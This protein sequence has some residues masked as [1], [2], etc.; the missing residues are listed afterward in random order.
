MATLS[1]EQLQKMRVDVAHRHKGV[2]WQKSHVNAAFQALE[3]WFEN[4][5]PKFVAL[6]DIALAPVSTTNVQKKR[7]V[8]AYLQSKTDRER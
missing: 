4:E 1:E 6:L 3:D 2:V 5:R 8:G 7:I